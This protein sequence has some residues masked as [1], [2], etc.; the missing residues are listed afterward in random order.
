MKEKISIVVFFSVLLVAS[1]SR[2]QLVPNPTAL[3][4]TTFVVSLLT[5]SDTPAPSTRAISETL[6][7][8][9]R[10]SEVTILLFSATSPHHYVNYIS[11][12]TAKITDVTGDITKKQFSVFIPDGSYKALFIANSADYIATLYNL[13]TGMVAGGSTALTTLTLSA[14]EGAMYYVVSGKWNAS[15]GSSGY[16][17]FPMSSQAVDLAIPN[18]VNYLSNPIGMVRALSKVNLKVKSTLLGSF[19]IDT[20]R[21]CNYHTNGY[22]V[23]ATGWGS[24]TLFTSS[25]T[26][27]YGSTT[28][29][30]T[31]LSYS[32]KV[33]GSQCIDEIFTCEQAAPSNESNWHDALCLLVRATGTTTS[34]ISFVGRWYRLDFLKSDPGDNNAVKHVNILR[35]FSYTLEIIGV[36]NTGYAT[37]QEA[38]NNASGGISTDLSAAN[39]I[40]ELNDIT[41]NGQYQIAVDRSLVVIK[42]SGAA[43][44][45]RVY[46]DYSQG[47]KV[48]EVNNI[49]TWFTTNH[50]TPNQ[51][52]MANTSTPTQVTLTAQPNATGMVRIAK[53]TLSAGNLRKTITVLQ[54]PAT[55]YITDNTPANVNTYVGAFWRAEQSGERLIRIA[56]PTTSPVNALDGAWVAVVVEGDSWIV[57]DDKMTNDVNVGWRSDVTPIESGVHNGNDAGFD[58]VHAVT[59]G[60]TMVNGTMSAIAG[61]SIYFRIGLKSHYQ[62]TPSDPAR[63][64]VVLL[65]AKDY[66]VVQRIWIRQGHDPDYLMRKEDNGAG[67]PWGSPD[68]R[69]D[70]VKF[71]PYN[72][73]APVTF[74]NTSLALYGGVF[75][76]YPSQAG[77]LFQWAN[78]T[79]TRY[80]WDPFMAAGPSHWDYMDNPTSTFWT[81]GIT[82]LQ[83]IHETCPQEYRRPYDGTTSAFNPNGLVTGSAMRQSLWVNPPTGNSLGTSPVNPN[84]AWGYYADGFFDRRQVVS[85]PGVDAGSAVSVT[86]ERIAYT[87]GLFYNPNTY[88]SLFFPAGGNRESGGLLTAGGV[89][90]Y[91]WSSSVYD[92]YPGWPTNGRI[93]MLSVNDMA[94]VGRNADGLINHGISIR[95][96]YN[97]CTPVS[98]VSFDSQPVSGTIMLTGQ[99]LYLSATVS[100]VGVAGVEYRWQYHNGV[101]W[102]TLSTTTTPSLNATIVDGNNQFRVVVNNNCYS[103]VTSNIITITGVTLVGGSAARITW[104]SVNERYALT[105]DPRDAG[106]YFRYGSVVGL[107]SG[108]GR[109]TQDL[110]QGTNTSVFNAANHVTINVSTVTINGIGDLPYVSTDT[111]INDVFHTAAN[112]KAGR[113]DPCRLIGLDLNNIKNKTALQLTKGEIDNGLWR[114]PTGAEQR[115]FSGY[116]STQNGS[117]GVWWWALGANPLGFTL[118]IPGGEFPERNHVNGGP[119][120]FLPAVG[121]RSNYGEAGRQ[122][123]RGFFLTSTSIGGNFEGFLLEANQIMFT[124]ASK[125]WI[126]PARCVSQ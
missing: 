64:G 25:S 18:S 47:W 54:L 125:D 86:D 30:F 20:L 78:G 74:Y 98:S 51:T 73:T 109:H 83:T 32:S 118:G 120:K 12:P 27:P 76:A 94:G 21:L 70:A 7:E 112:V 116:S 11:V 6:A 111:N 31:G 38:Y 113:G 80:A 59:G 126:W 37:E 44:T 79:R 24:G 17:P 2:E 101:T 89:S 55:G 108:A 92:Y 103:E 4:G 46:T 57:L 28:T 119:G 15:P 22:L 84:T 10:I 87:G 39:D 5:H 66:T 71:S 88:A 106:L 33:S 124:S 53:M 41:Y 91:Y 3:G 43:Q 23:P 102:V 42:S 67:G 69:P 105:T 60:S 13:S 72:L 40:E 19:A 34:G 90:G 114:L 36:D 1:C 100:P 14:M 48:A 8:D 110:S 85:A 63:Y 123:S 115:S 81:G 99:T 65:L 82:P 45:L 62:A 93:W 35:N 104:D 9:N 49:G 52:N 56:R 50:I 26:R 117:P 75:T 95:C 61:S 58:D 16:R 121:D 68:P 29:G 77:A 122:R 107:F 96:I 97:P